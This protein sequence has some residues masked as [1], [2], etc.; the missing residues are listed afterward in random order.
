MVARVQGFP[1]SWKFAGRK[2]AAYRQ[3]GNAFP[4]PVAAA[5]GKAIFDALM[6]AE[7]KIIFT[8]KEL[9]NTALLCEATLHNT[10]NN[11]KRKT[12]TVSRRTRK[13]SL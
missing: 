6:F 8:P 2:T 11:E 7:R 13:I 1:D 3:V 5:V 12:R 10:T 9:F 4:P